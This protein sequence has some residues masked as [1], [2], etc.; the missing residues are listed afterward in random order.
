[1]KRLKVNRLVDWGSKLGENDMSYRF[2]SSIKKPI[3][4]KQSRHAA[5]P[6][7]FGDWSE[8]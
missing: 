5:R 4:A 3:K 1:M 6:G 7:Q 2:F 8:R